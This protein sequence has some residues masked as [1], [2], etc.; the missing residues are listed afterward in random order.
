MFNV[1][2]DSS[3]WGR[4]VNLRISLKLKINNRRKFLFESIVFFISII[5]RSIFM[6]RTNDPWLKMHLFDYKQ[7]I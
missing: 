4:V 5:F 6:L 7:S 1:Q 2:R 3:E